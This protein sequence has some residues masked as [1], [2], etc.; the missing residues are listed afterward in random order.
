MSWV[1][2]VRDASCSRRSRK[3]SHGP[4]PPRDPGGFTGEQE[5]TRRKHASE[6]NLAAVRSL[7]EIAQRRGRT[8]A[9]GPRVDPCAITRVTSTLVGASSVAQLEDNTWRSR[10]C[11]SPPRN[12]PTRMTG[13][14]RRV[15]WTSGR[16]RGPS[17]GTFV[18][19]ASNDPN[20][21]HCRKPSRR[22]RPPHLARDKASTS[23]MDGIMFHRWM[24]MKGFRR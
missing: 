7:S 2:R 1:E 23:S 10:T 11:P 12:S 21:A 17:D 16:S 6:E 4:L 20:V 8:L 18:A 19:T 9:D 14:R 24:S 15:A 5:S 3:G 13:M 22:G